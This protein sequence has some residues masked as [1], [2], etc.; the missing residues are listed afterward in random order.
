MNDKP[1]PDTKENPAMK[2]FSLKKTLPCAAVLLAA[3]SL[4]PSC[5]EKKD[6][7][8]VEPLFAPTIESMEANFRMPQ[9]YEDAKFGIFTHWGP[10][11]QPESGD[12]Y[13]RNMYIP[14]HW[15]F[16]RHKEKYGDQKTFGFKDV[17]N[18]WKGDKWDPAE[19][20]QLFKSMG[21]KYVVSMANHHDNLD[22]W[23]SKYQEWNSVRVGPKRDIIGEWSKAVRSAGLHWGVS[24]HA[25]HAW[26]W[27][28]TSRDFDGMLTK[29]D[30]AGT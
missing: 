7:E 26:N 15:H 27:Y 2:H 19:L 9:W 10:Q 11:C 6:A 28:E 5:T 12:W 18:E 8:P 17:I 25:S 1:Q 23:D 16:N 20:A 29:E 21:A 30:G 4:L 13:A 3:A 14:N 22:L 24:V